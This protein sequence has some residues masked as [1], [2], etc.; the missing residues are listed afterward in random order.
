[1]IKN[2]QEQKL[3]QRFSPLQIQLMNMLAMPALAFEEYLANEIE[4][5]PALEADYPEPGETDA[6]S[7]PSQDE[8]DDDT[9]AADPAEADNDFDL[10]DYIYEDEAPDYVPSSSDRPDPQAGDRNT[11]IAAQGA[12]S[13]FTD[14][15]TEQLLLEPLD[16][17][18]RAIGRYIIGNLDPDGYLRRSTQ[19]IADDLAFSGTADATAQQVEE[20]LD[21]IRTFDPPG[22]GAATLQQCL[23]LQLDQQPDTPAVTLARRIVSDYFPLLAKKNFDALLEKTGGSRE[24]LARAIEEIGRLNPKPGGAYL[25]GSEVSSSGV[26]PDFVVRIEDG[27]VE[28]SLSESDHLPALRVSRQ[29]AEMIRDLSKINAPTKSQQETAAFVRGKIDAA[30]WFIEAVNQRRATLLRIMRAIAHRQRRYLLSGD[31]AD[32]VP[33]G[34]KDIAADVSMDISTVSRVASQK[35]ADTPYGVMRLK[36][37]FSEGAVNRE[38]EDISTREVKEC[39]SGLIEGEDKNTPYT[40]EQLTALLGEKGYNIARRTVAKYREALGHPTA[41][42][43]RRL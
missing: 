3:A 29:Y 37:F 22:V 35:Y 31:V 8:T 7:D 26:T 23:S 32:M 17:T 24:E 43:R 25:Q 39:L 28:T 42:L 4:S 10:E 14:H 21:L 30:R 5:N 20:V 1:M 34:L 36:D 18:Q 40:D 41:R 15:L 11:F 27:R 12:Q 38:G 13:S 6:P 2:T 33:L 16:E 9:P 19:E